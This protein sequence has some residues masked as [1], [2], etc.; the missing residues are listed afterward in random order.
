MENGKEEKKTYWHVAI[1]RDM[2]TDCYDFQAT[3]R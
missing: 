2:K 3:I 1:I